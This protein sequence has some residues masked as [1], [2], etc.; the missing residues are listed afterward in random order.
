M[1]GI[2]EAV[3]I[4]PAPTR[5][6]GRRQLKRLVGGLGLAAALLLGTAPP[7]AADTFP[8][9]PFDMSFAGA[10]WV[11]VVRGVE[12]SWSMGTTIDHLT[13]ETSVFVGYFA[14]YEIRCGGGG[15]GQADVFF[16]AIGPGFARIRSDLSLALAAANVQGTEFTFRSCGDRFSESSRPRR[17]SVGLA[18][19]ANGDPEVSTN[20]GCVDFEDGNGPILVTDTITSR[21]AQGVAT[22]DQQPVIVDGGM[23]HDVA[24]AGGSC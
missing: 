15:T 10:S 14:S 21:S 3:T 18:L 5:R 17:F 9:P 24:T 22:V 20:Q 4:R 1:E 19:R 23:S 8:Q 13:G 16:D 7:A 2:A 12:Y 11:E 6:R